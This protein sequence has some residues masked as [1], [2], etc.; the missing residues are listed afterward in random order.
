MPCFKP[1]QAWRGR[2]PGPSGKVPVVFKQE[3]SCGVSLEL[4]CGQCIGCR[5]ERSRQWAVRIMH[6]ASLHEDNCFL[7]LTYS[8]EFVPVTGSLDKRHFQLFC[9]RLR[10]ARGPF[11][12]FHCGEY[13]DK[14]G[15]PHYHA[16]I[17]GL[18]FPDKEYFKLT[19]AGERIFRSDSLDAF[20]RLGHCSIG[21]LTFESAAYVSRY[22]MKK[23][24]GDAADEHYMR[25]SDYGEVINMLPEYVTMSRRPGIAREWFQKFGNE[26]YPADEVISRGIS[27]RPPRYYD[28]ILEHSEPSVFDAIKRR[29]LSDV[30]EHVADCTPER[31]RVREICAEARVRQLKRG[32]S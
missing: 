19:D 25:M 2:K 5:L 22:V 6:E 11:R 30:R 12:F 9:K 16:C 31:L 15:R 29:R 7:T 17:F 24:T 14:L 26:V 13:G 18:D 32:I 3:D 27:C 10:K 23:V 8:D 4:P 28:N 1:L 21:S 20:W